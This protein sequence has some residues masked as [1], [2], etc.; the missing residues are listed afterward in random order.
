MYVMPTTNKN[1]HICLES[2][3]GYY[4]CSMFMKELNGVHR[5]KISTKV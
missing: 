3:N 1:M 4:T 2:L 5:M